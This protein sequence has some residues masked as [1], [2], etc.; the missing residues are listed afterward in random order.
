MTNTKKKEGI[1]LV[2][3]VITIILLLILAGVSISVVNGDGLFTKAKNGTEAYQEAATNEAKKLNEYEN[4]MVQNDTEGSA[5]VTYNIGQIV[6]F[7]NEDFYVIEKSDDTSNT[8][9]LLA[10]KCI[11]VNTYSQNGST[12]TV[13]FDESTNDYSSS[14][15]KGIVDDYVSALQN[16]TGKNIQEGRLLLLQEARNLETDHRSIIYGANSELYYWLNGPITSFG[17]A[18]SYN[19]SGTSGGSISYNP[20]NTGGT[21]GVRPVIIILKTNL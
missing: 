19:V 16:R 20:V 14:T 7:A 21:W 18:N 13:V 11:D 4:Y 17:K 15:I 10:K 5:T 3:L 2:A 12:S 8:V 1:T 9:K 6:P